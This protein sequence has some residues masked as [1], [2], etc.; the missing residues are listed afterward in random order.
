ML[1]NVPERPISNSYWVIPGKL[2]AGEYP[3]SVYDGLARQMIRV[4][5]ECGIDYFLDL[6]E[7]GEVGLKSYTPYLKEAA[8]RLGVR[9]IQKRWPIRDFSVPKRGF[10]VQ[11]LDEMDQA[12]ADGH[13]VYLHC[14]GGIGRT[15]TVVGCYLVRHGMNGNEVLEQIAAWRKGIPSERRNSP[16][17]EAQRRM[18]LNWKE[19]SK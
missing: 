7:E 10:L 2:L 6:T 17:T 19:K 14:F 16:E 12:L 4:L 15:G 1:P 9:F 18:V 11:I 8:D 3:S 13:R 5:L